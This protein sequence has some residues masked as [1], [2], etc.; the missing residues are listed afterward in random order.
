MVNNHPAYY[1]VLATTIPQNEKSIR[2]LIKLGLHFDK[3]ITV[4]EERL[5]VY[6]NRE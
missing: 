6:S 2:L 3:E 1:P 5:L 4:E